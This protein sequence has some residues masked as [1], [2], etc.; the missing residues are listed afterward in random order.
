MRLVIAWVILVGIAA[1]SRWV[2]APAVRT[3]SE[4]KVAAYEGGGI[5]P[6]AAVVT[7]PFVGG[8]LEW[9]LPIL[10]LAGAV[11]VTASWVGAKA[12]RR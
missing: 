12:K 4:N 7:G 2:A 5:P 6:I 10:C 3:W 8:L 11:S 1:L 9:V